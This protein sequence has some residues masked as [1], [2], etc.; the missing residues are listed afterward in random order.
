MLMSRHHCIWFI[1]NNWNTVPNVHHFL[2]L[3]NY[4]F[5]MRHD[6]LNDLGVIV[7]IILE[8]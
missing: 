6:G 8:I 2:P 7:L 1:R 5:V 3:M 4:C